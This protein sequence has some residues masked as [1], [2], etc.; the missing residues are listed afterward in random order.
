M[1]EQF[2]AA[3][4]GGVAGFELHCRWPRASSLPLSTPILSRHRERGRREMEGKGSN[5]YSGKRLVRTGRA[6][7]KEWLSSRVANS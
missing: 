7:F 5:R 1:E 3:D 2:R 4:G 6:A